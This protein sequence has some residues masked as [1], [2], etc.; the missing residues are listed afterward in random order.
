M[1]V[2][3]A[4]EGQTGPPVITGEVSPAVEVGPD[5]ESHADVGAVGVRADTDVVH[6]TAGHGPGVHRMAVNDSA[7]P[8]TS[9]HPDRG[10]AAIRGQGRRRRVHLEASHVADP[11][12]E[13]HL[14]ND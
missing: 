13:V 10:H 9:W 14:S 3:V 4:L 8:E 12:V 7:S 1:I 6:R 11:A 2:T 5:R